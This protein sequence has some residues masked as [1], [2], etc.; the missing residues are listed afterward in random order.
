M[1]KPSTPELTSAEG[2]LGY[3][4][5]QKTA[6]GTGPAWQDVHMSVFSLTADAEQ[7]DMPAVT[8]PFVAWVTGGRAETRERETGGDWIVCQVKP[9]SLY[10]TMSGAPYEF[11]WKR[12]SA[13]PFEIVLLLLSHRRD[14]NAVVVPSL[15][16]S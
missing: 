7:F 13:E 12:L 1:E 8:E 3:P 2:L 4:P 9:G 6:L 15:S 11:R 16:P 10:L 5:G 14:N